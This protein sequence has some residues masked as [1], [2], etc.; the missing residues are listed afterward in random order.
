MS[1]VAATPLQVRVDRPTVLANVRRR[2][3]YTFIVLGSILAYFFY[4][5]G[6]FD[7]TGLLKS[8][9]PERAVLLAN[10]AVAH[11][12]HVTKSMRTGELEIAIEG[13]RTATYTEPP[14][15]VQVSGDQT[16]LVDM[17][18][19]Y[20]VEIFEKG[21]NFS[22]PEYGTINVSLRDRKIETVLPEGKD[23]P[24]WLRATSSKFDARPV[25]HKRIQMSRAKIEV[26]RYYGGWENFF[27]PFN[28]ELRSYSFTEIVSLAFSSERIDPEKANWKFIF[29]T[30]WTNPD[31]Q[32][33][34]VFKA[35]LETL[36]MAVL[37]TFVAAFVALPLAFFAARN[38]SPS[39][40]LLFMVRRMFD[41][42]RG[43]DMLIW[44]L[45][46]IR[47]FGLGPLTGTLAIAFTEI[48][49]LGKLFSEALENIDK[50]QVDG[51]RSTGA[52]KPQVYRFGVIPQ[53]LPIFISQSLYYL[54]SNIRSATVIG[55]LG[56]GG[57][58]LMLVETIRTS[59]DWENTLY[60]V[61]LTL[62][63]VITIDK[64][65]TWLRRRMIRGR[66]EA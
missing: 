40:V 3:L 10:D 32:H 52:S 2:T 44:S 14:D 46:F 1:T 8:A 54:E 30:F 50:K 11:K 49:E 58:G 19:G 16:A 39:K 66:A 31:W 27:F 63:L 23:A 64:I 57:I 60:L 55:A 56:A 59:R 38:F 61:I 20:T 5:W 37:G 47:A 18:D 22:V 13:E 51:V 35:L 45:I 4:T 48:G 7:M 33:G 24:E 12:V 28:S 9:K 26:H 36:L 43:I 42:L 17:G 41:L 29:D 65:S 21:L 62:M 15:W 25:L 6:A 53:I 34:N